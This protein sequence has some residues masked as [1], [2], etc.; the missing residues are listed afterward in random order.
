MPGRAHGRGGGRHAVVAD[1]AHDEAVGDRLHAR[2]GGRRVQAAGFERGGHSH[3]IGRNVPITT[4][5]GVTR[6][7]TGRTAVV[8]QPSYLP[9][10][11]YFDLVD[12]ADV[13]V[14]YDDVQYDKHGWRNRNRIKTANGV[15]WLTVPVHAHGAVEA[16]TPIAEI[17]IDHRR[18]WVR[19]HAETLRHAY[20][21]QPFY[22]RYAPLIASILERRHERLADLTIELTVA[23]ARE[24]GCTTEFV[25]SSAFPLQ[26]PQDRPAARSSW[27]ASARTTTSAARRRARTSRPNDSTPRASRSSTRRTTTRR[28]RSRTR[29]T[30]PP[31][32]S[33]TRCSRW[34]RRPST[35]SARGAAPRRSSR[36]RVQQAARDGRRAALHHRSDRGRA[37]VGRR[38]LQP[39]R[40]GVARARDATRSARC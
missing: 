20:R 18:D 9:W 13:F 25:R 16:G 32:R 27:R 33:S 14:F 31:F 7:R 40:P 3:S 6:G 10:R 24:L 35:T 15:S 17:A 29:R 28:T 1:G 22:A 21:R 23:I 4:G 30:K 2:A 12:R 5:M 11:G 39:A 36:D 37:P 8:L 19:A 26:R 34:V 38:A